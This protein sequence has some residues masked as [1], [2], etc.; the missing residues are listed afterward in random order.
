VNALESLFNGDLTG[1]REQRIHTP[2]PMLRCLELLWPEGIALDPCGSP[3]GIVKAQRIVIPPENGLV[4]E[5]PERTYANP[6]YDDLQ[7]WLTRY[8]RSWEVVLLVPVRTHRPW[9]RT[10][11]QRTSKIVFLDPITFV[12]FASS[13][14]AP[15][16][17]LYRGER[18]LAAAALRSGITSV[19][20]ES[21][22]ELQI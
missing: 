21:Q 20:D 8:R 14:P 9:F 10:A 2:W 12:G 11:L 5:W 1:E 18:D 13:F 17:L 16:C 6:P 7:P 3:D 19:E 15:L 4:I 22:M